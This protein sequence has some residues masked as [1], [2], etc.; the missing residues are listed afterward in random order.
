MFAI[1]IQVGRE[2][3]MHL[4]NKDLKIY[5]LYIWYGS[6]KH[7]K[8]NPIILSEPNLDIW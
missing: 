5:E 6:K 2:D 4:E 1:L 8:H 7:I 3:Q